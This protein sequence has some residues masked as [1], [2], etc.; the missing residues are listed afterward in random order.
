MPEQQQQKQ[1][2][3]G[4]GFM[5]LLLGGAVRE[6]APP[7]PASSEA[8]AG[9]GFFD[10]LLRGG[11]VASAVPGKGAEQKMDALTDEDKEMQKRY[12]EG[13]QKVLDIIAP[14][15]MEVNFK[16]VKVGERCARSFFVYNWPSQIIPGW[17]S[18]IIN[19]DA[20]MDIAQY[21]YPTANDAVLRMLRKKVTEIRSTIHIRQEKGFS[22][23]PQLQAALEDAELLRDLLA[24]GYEKLFAFGLYFTIYAPT[25]E[26]LQQTQIQLESM[27]G[28]K[29][30]LTKPAVFQQE[31]AFNSVLPLCLDE[32]EINRN[33]N[34]SPLATTFP[35]N[36]SDLTSD[37]GILYGINRHNDSLIIFDRFSLPNANSTVFATSG[38][39]KSYT[40]KLEVLRSLMVGTE[41]FVIDPENEYRELAEVVGGAV[42]PLSLSSSHRINPFDL[43]AHV[44]NVGEE[45]RQGDT[46]RAAAVNLHGL[47]KLMLGEIS[48]DEDSILDRAILD[49]YALKGITMET[50]NPGSMEPPLLGD[51]IDVLSTTRGGENMAKTLSKFTQGSLAG[52][53]DQQT[54][55]SVNTQLMVFQTRDLEEILR[56][57]AIYIVL[58]F[59]WNRIRSKIKKRLIIIDEAWNLMQY[60]DSASFL[61]GIFKRAR[62]YFLGITTITQDIDDFM[63]SSFGKPIITNSSMQILLKQAPTAVKSLKEAFNL[64]QGECYLLLN[65]AVGQGV[66]FAGKKHVAIQVVASFKENEIVTTNP[67]EMARRQMR[68]EAKIK[69]QLGIRVVEGAVEKESKEPEETPSAAKTM[70][71]KGE[72]K[73]A[74]SAGETRTGSGSGAPDG[75]AADS[76]MSNAESKEPPQGRLE[77]L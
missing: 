60:E 41:V 62:K 28:G 20:E 58:N 67:E 69:E 50:K 14:P 23:D 38:A 65:A 46:L 26:K 34:T 56:P 22:R 27:L 40:V 19:L 44:Q 47:F 31:H 59:L 61:F 33:M 51:L 16:Y 10:M 30:I 55:V 64:T 63:K 48:P 8:A 52:M 5:D 13:L 18:N 6:G 11:G 3:S 43:P 24:R 25:L 77:N 68:K 2:K 29:L 76:T 4:G 53:F 32:I 36:S 71:G 42:V 72:A 57:M 75:P 49:T 45:A 54:N 35:F 1:V 12:E 37:S 21:I 7:A 9:G 15:G 17:L 74:G 70:E 66:F 39:G 73:E